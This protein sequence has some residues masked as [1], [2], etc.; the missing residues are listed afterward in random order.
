MSRL[1][2]EIKKKNVIF[3]ELLLCFENLGNEIRSKSITAERVETWS[4]VMG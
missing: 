4:A 2:G 1:P 3:L